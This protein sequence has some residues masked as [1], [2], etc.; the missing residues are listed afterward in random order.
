MRLSLK[1]KFTLATSL[2]VLAV[3]TVVSGLYLGRLT[4]Q[5]LRQADD[6]ARFVA[7]QVFFACQNALAD[8]A[9]RGDAPASSSPADL[10]EYVQRALD[11]SSTLNSLMES[12]IGYSP[13]IYEITISDRDGIVSGFQRRELARPENCRAA[14]R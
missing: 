8:A 9:E 2:L 11:N 7:Q 3:V 4:R 12:A 5:V 13:T 1:T 6:R 14:R 10:R